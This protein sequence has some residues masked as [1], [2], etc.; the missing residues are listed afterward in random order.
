[1]LREGKKILLGLAMLLLGTTFNGFDVHSEI[2]TINSQMHRPIFGS[3]FKDPII[4][5]KE[6]VVYVEKEP[7]VEPD[8]AEE[9]SVQEEIVVQPLNYYFD[10]FEPTNYSYDDLYKA[11]DTAPHSGLQHLIPAFID[12]EDIYG[13]NALYL[14]SVI[15]W[16][17]GWGRYHSGFNN[18]AGWKG[19]PGGTWSDFS[20]E[21]ECIM[22]VAEA[23]STY[24]RDS[25]GCYLLD[26]ARMYCP[27][28]GY[29]DNILQ[30]M[31]EME[32]EI[33]Y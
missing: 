27:D 30:I 31:N 25:V 10:V 18:I 23:L 13:V 9:Y 20:S 21:Y 7:E 22:T 17:S 2:R 16:E 24:Y 33:L 26:V 6:V 28:P 11:L 5:E 14:L 19:G 15:G 29:R 4:I 12:A 8:I 32:S 1:M 3:Y